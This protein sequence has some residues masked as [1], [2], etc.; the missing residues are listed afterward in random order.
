MNKIKRVSQI[1]RILIFA[2]FILVPLLQ[3]LFWMQAPKPLSLGNFFSSGTGVAV[4]FIPKAVDILHP[5]TTANRANGF[6]VSLIP[7]AIVML[8]C[9]YLMSLFK[10]YQN[11]IIFSLEN[12]RLIKKLGVT[13]SIS[14]LVQPFYQF[15]LSMSLTWENPI[16]Q[17]Y[18]LISLNQTNIAILLIGLI[19]ILISWI[20]AEGHKLK[21]EQDFTV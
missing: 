14:Q 6:L 1:F 5:F 21:E 7:T 18:G 11:G 4:T 15:L 12:V 10:L 19:L 13:L 17:R 2:I 9:Y 8:I 16:H 20:M 3:T